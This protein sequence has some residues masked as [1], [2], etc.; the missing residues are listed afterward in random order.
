MTTNGV[1]FKHK[2]RELKNAGLDQ[3]NISLDSLKTER[4]LLLTGRNIFKL[5]MASILTALEANFETVR[6]I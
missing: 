4:V 2:A 6:V 3:V 5:T 1:A